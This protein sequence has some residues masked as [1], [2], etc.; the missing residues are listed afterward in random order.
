MSLCL[1]WMGY[2]TAFH[3]PSLWSQGPSHIPNPVIPWKPRSSFMVV[4]ATAVPPIISLPSNSYMQ[5]HARHAFHLCP[6]RFTTCFS[7]ETPWEMQV[8]LRSENE[9]LVYESKYKVEK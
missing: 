7:T 6:P 8:M 1:R 2:T 9:N 5:C 3:A 4:I